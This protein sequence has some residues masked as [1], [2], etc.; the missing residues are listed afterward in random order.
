LENLVGNADGEA[1]AEVAD[2]AVKANSQ[3]QQYVQQRK[4]AEESKASEKE[5]PATAGPGESG[6]AKKNKKKKKK[7]K[8]TDEADE[9]DDMAF[10]DQVIQEKYTC[11]ADG[12]ERSI[13][14]GWCQ[15]RSCRRR[16]CPLHFDA[17]KHRCNPD[18]KKMGSSL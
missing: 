16:F 4:L 12:C 2:T 1:E 5:R 17:S 13:Q 14:M 7:D 6:E 11:P 10:L 18:H 3:F 9:L 15:C 8:R